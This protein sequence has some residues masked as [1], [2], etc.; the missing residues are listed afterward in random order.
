MRA[1]IEVAR[2]IL[3]ERIQR[4]T[5]EDMMDVLVPEPQEQIVA[6]VTVQHVMKEIAEVARPISQ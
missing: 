1:T 4:R 6:A 3:Q 5:V 2:L